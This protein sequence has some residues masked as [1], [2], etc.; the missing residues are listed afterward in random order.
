MKNNEHLIQFANELSKYVNES[1]ILESE[2]LANISSAIIK[3]R[4]EMGMNQKD[5]ASFMNVSQSMISKW[6][7]SNYNFTIHTLAMILS[8]LNISI[9]SI[10]NGISEKYNRKCNL[11]IYTNY[12]KWN[13]I[14]NKTTFV[15][16]SEYLQEIG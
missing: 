15:Q 16:E 5:F 13:F 14:N 11:N 9:N 7:S 8:K 1:D 12:P 6:E 2:I 4:V 3:K 10:F